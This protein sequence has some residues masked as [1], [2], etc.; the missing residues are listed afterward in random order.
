MVKTGGAGQFLESIGACMKKKKTLVKEKCKKIDGIKVFIDCEWTSEN[1]PISVQ[2]L[3]HYPNGVV[4]KYIVINSIYQQ[5]VDQTI[6]NKWMEKTG[7]IMLFDSLSEDNCIES[8][9]LLH[10]IM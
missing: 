3:I 4:G 8:T 6:I 2:C 9:L 10:I 1:K 7:S 5:Q